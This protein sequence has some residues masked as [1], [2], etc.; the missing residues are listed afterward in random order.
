MIWN[1]NWT[2][3]LLAIIFETVGTTAMKMSSGFT[4]LGPAIVMGICYILCFT[5]LTLALKQLDVSLA[6]AIWSGVGTALITII[7]IWWFNESVSTLKVVSIVLII[8]GVIGLHISS[9][10]DEGQSKVLQAQNS[11]KAINSD[12]KD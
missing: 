1:M 5:L 3:L 9:S 12:T 10:G 8:L 2:F 7:G 4:R 11:S 6:Y